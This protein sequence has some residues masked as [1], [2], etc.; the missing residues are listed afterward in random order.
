MKNIIVITGASSGIGREFAK[1]LDK[2]CPNNI[3]EFWLIAR[4][5]D[6]LK[7][8]ANI[9][10]HRSVLFPYDL[11]DS[12]DMAK[13]AY[14]LKKEDC[15][16]RILVNSAGFGLI[17]RFSELNI[18]KQLDMIDINCKAIVKLTYIA[19][20]YMKKNSRIINIASSAAFCPQPNFAI[21]AATKAFV[22]SF[23]QAI[24]RE[25]NNRQIYVTSVCPGPVKTEFFD[26]AL[27]G[28]EYPLYKKLFMVNVKNVV[29]CAIRDSINRKNTSIYGIPMKLWNIISRII[30]TKILMYLY[31]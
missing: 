30:P 8:L 6:K 5:E 9:L 26:T 20:P 23:N 22:N 2:K 7:D 24:N 14:N 25:L 4:R 12:T 31:R 10:K 18:S 19:L 29:D 28:S 27:A 17:G 15:C 13:L 16:I 21:Y 1:Q 11:A 3:D